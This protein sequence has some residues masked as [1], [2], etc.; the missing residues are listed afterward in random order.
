MN[1]NHVQTF[2]FILSYLNYFPFE[3][4]TSTTTTT[5]T[6]TTPT[7]TTGKYSFKD[8]FYHTEKHY[9]LET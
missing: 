6:T 1:F 7:T 3:A 5:T 9:L 2:S 4:T 8:H